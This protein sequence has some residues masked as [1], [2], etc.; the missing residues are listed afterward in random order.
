[1]IYK[2]LIITM[3]ATGFLPPPAQP[4][5]PHANDLRTG[6]LVWTARMIPGKGEP[7]GDSWGPRDARSGEHAAAGVIWRWMTAS[8]TVYVPTDS[9][10]PD[11]VGIWRP[12][13]NAGSGSTVAIDAATGKIKWRFQEHAS[14]HLR[15]GHQCRARAGGDHQGRQAH[16]GGGAGHQA[17]DDLDSGCPD[18]QAHSSLTKS[19][20]WRK[21]RSRA[22]KPR[23]PSLSPFCRRRCCRPR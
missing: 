22:K 21:A 19:G 20:R 23:P 2:N 13:D 8:G 11:Y 10:S 6:K 7:G 5:D 18:R 9:G 4:G 14:R 16:E 17:V 3:G 12:G 15:P 1:M